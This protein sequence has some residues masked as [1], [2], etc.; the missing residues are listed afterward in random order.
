MFCPLCEAEFDRPIARCP[1]C[2]AA[3]V[4]NEDEAE[5]SVPR[6]VVW[7]GDHPDFCERLTEKLT[8]RQI[9]NFATRRAE[10]IRYKWP[11]HDP[12]FHVYVLESDLES[13]EKVLERVQNEFAVDDSAAIGITD[14]IRLED[15]EVPRSAGEWREGDPSVEVWSGGD[16]SLADFLRES[17]RTN[18]ID[19]RT[20]SDPGKPQKL[21]VRLADKARAQEIVREVVEG[22]PPE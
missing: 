16:A 10:S 22:A 6:S 2:G 7:E 14:S 5:R 8:E 1:N 4:A 3:L 12:R 18:E 19:F 17:L 20:R 13:A 15:S 21:E 9:N 11:M